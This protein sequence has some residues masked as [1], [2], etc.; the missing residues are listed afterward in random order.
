MNSKP[1]LVVITAGN[2]GHCRN[3]KQVWPDIQQAIE[4]TG[5]VRVVNIPLEMMSSPIDTNVYPSD[6]KTYKLWFP[7]FLLVSGS[8]WNEAMSN[9]QAE[10]PLQAKVMS[11]EVRPDGRIQIS[12]NPVYPL[13]KENIINWIRATIP[14]LPSSDLKPIIP[15]MPMPKAIA[16]IAPKVVLPSK[17]SYEA[18]AV[19]YTTRRY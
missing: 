7:M 13:N 19:K 5:L 4:G 17:G 2:C 16:P 12:S 10:V 6:L 18:C 1:V 11:G 15:G 9:T 8:T 14:D 3:L